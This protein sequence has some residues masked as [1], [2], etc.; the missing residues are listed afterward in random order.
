MLNAKKTQRMFAG[1]RGL[2]YRTPSDTHMLVDG[3]PNF[4]SN[5]TT[6]LDNHFDAHMKV[7]TD[8]K[9][10]SRKVYGLI[11]YINRIKHNFN[12]SS[13][14]SVIQSLILSQ[15]TYGI[16]IWGTV[17]STPFGR[18]KKKKK[19]KKKF[20]Q[21][22]HLQ[23]LPNVTALLHTLKSLDGLKLSKNTTLNW[24]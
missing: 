17:N 5:T 19:K 6:N 24:A 7:D 2:L 1:T 4:P 21:K 22:F 15:I 11:M 16:C 3:T 8:V 9:E 13:R 14:I 20:Q 23:A 10:L 12:K 18:E